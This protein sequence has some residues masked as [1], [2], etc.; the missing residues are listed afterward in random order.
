MAK[1]E[2][3]GGR[4]LGRRSGSWL[5]ASGIAWALAGC[6]A[7]PSN[8]QKVNDAARD[9]N[10]AARFGNLEA[11]AALAAPAVRSDFLA[12]RA[13][14]G[15]EIRI[16]DVELVDLRMEAEGVRAFVE[17]NVSWMRTSE[18][19]LRTTRIAQVWR[20]RDGDWLLTAEERV[21]GDVGI[22]GEPVEVLRPAAEPRQF[23][24]RRLKALVE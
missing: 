13:L 2:K 20:E 12:R 19:N 11:A 21:A 1:P 7:P 3:R 15:D 4:G 9:L 16:L 10:L 8:A 5:V 6:F 22:F 18:S 17:V 23:E 24:T 14:W